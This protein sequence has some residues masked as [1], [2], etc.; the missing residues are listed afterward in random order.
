[1]SRP[2]R[3]AD[4]LGDDVEVAE[5]GDVLV[6]LHGAR[7]RVSTVRAVVRTW[8][9]RRLGQEALVRGGFTA[10]GPIDEP[11]RESFETHIRVWL[12][13]PHLAGSGIG[14]ELGWLQD[15]APLIGG[16]TSAR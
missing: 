10:Y 5:L 16:S 1:M 8:Q 2:A 13:P 4:G 12:A 15:P 11:E 14:G 9:H 7:D 3:A 6:L